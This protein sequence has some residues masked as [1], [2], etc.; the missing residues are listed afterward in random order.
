MGNSQLGT[1]RLSNLAAQ[2]VSPNKP[3]LSTPERAVRF[4]GTR[5]TDYRLPTIKPAALRPISTAKFVPLS[6][7]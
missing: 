1:A 2:P 3:A 5:I 6:Q 7:G 4:Y